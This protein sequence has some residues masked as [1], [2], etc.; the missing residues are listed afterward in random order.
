MKEKTWFVIEAGF[1]LISLC[2]IS[3]LAGCTLSFTNVMTSGNASDVVDSDPKTQSQIDAT[4][5]MRIVYL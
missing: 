3:M 1:V 5:P 4:I 2:A